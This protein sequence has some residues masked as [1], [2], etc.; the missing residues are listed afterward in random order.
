MT[1]QSHRAD[2]F[3]AQHY[4]STPLLLPN[5]WDAGSARLLATLGFEALATTSSGLAAARGRSDGGVP[6]DEVLE[7]VTD[8]VAATDLP[9]SADL[10]NCYADDPAGVA[11]TCR[12]ALATGAAGFSIEDYTGTAD[13]PIYAAGLAAERVAAAADVAH[14]VDHRLVVTARAENHIRGGAG[15]SDTIHRLQAFQDAGADVLY[16]P[17]LTDPDDIAAVLAEVDRPLNVLALPGAPS[18][19]ELGRLGVARVSVGGAFAFAAY[20]VLAQAGHELLENGTYGF[21]D[22]AATGVAAMQ[23]QTST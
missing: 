16:A 9:V 13:A 5:P 23:Q 19:A 21:S 8:L 15:L 18:I 12:A 1:A 14:D 11:E 7:H 4:E 2:R 20:G 6:R 22:A 3:R 17:G 10:E